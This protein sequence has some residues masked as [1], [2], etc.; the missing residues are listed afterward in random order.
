MSTTKPPTILFDIG[1]NEELTL[2]APELTQ[3]VKLLEANGLVPL[4]GNIAQFVE[5]PSN[6]EVVVLGNP[7][8]SSFA[9]EEIS[10][11]VSFV[12]SG[13]GLLLVSGATI[14]GKGG[15][16]ARNTNLN[17]ISNHFQF[18]FSTKALEPATETPEELITAVPA[19]DHPILAGIDQLFFTSGVSLKA[20][21]TET[22]LFRVN[23]IT[24][25]PTIAIATE[26]QKG[27]IVAFGGG[28]FFF[29]NYLGMGD[30]EHL[31]VQVFRWLSG[32]PMNLP[33]KKFSSPPIVMDE[34]GAAEAI[35]DLRQQLDKIEEELSSLK[36][37]INTSIKDME[38][39][40]RQVQDE[41]KES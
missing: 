26:F 38:K 24:G 7:L 37:V 16:A 30:H 23:N 25:S 34:M 1:H 32:E 19:G 2:D 3:L 10:T 21:N 31:V 35:A 11:L 28:T 15:D 36:E 12:E 33:I 20:V 8:D 18:E 41:E 17:E 40:V 6:F 27:R 13:G 22:H 39:L 9:P 29:N 14:F 4:V 5:D